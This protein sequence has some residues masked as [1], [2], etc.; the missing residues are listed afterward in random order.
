VDHNTQVSFHTGSAEVLARVRLLQ[1][2]S[3][4]A[5]ES[6]WAQMELNAPVAVVKGDFFVIRSPNATLGGG[7]IVDAHPKR[8]KRNRPEVIAALDTLARG[9][10][11]EVILHALADKPPMELA[12]LIAASGLPEDE[13]RAGLARL[14]A[15]GEALQLGTSGEAERALRPT[16]LVISVVGWRNLTQRASGILADY[17]RRFPLRQGMPKEEL[18]SRLGLA[19]RPFNEAIARWTLESALVDE[20]ATVRLPGHTVRFTSEQEQHVALVMAAMARTPYTPPS[21]ADLER[22]LGADVLQ[23][24]IDQAQLVKVSEDVLF[25][26]TTYHEMVERILTEIRTHGATNVAAVRDIF[27]TSR[28]YAIALLEHLDQTHVT[29]RQGDDRVLM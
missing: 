28:R 29:R 15:Q 14:L 13:T 1:G 23:A 21:R 18:K 16:T 20:G 19:P 27:N 26:P 4:S 10:P 7:Q 17:H 2:S 12:A 25:L 5:G 8:H 24:L 11:E 22:D 3:L 9:S 6:A